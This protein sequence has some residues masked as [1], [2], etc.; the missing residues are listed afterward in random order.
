LDFGF[1]SAQSQ[2]FQTCSFAEPRQNPKILAAQRYIFSVNALEIDS[3]PAC[4]PLKG[5]QL[6]NQWEQNQLLPSKNPNSSRRYTDHF[7]TRGLVILLV[8]TDEVYEPP[9]CR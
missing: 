6:L 3:S 9:N 2:G 8:L 7:F 5:G 1:I 4:R